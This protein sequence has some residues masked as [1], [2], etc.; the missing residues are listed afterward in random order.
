MVDIFIEFHVAYYNHGA[1]VKNRLR[2]AEYYLWGMFFFDFIPVT[3]MILTSFSY[4][5]ANLYVFHLLF[6]LKMYPVY[7]MD[8]RFVD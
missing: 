1:L 7:E 6:L 4:Y 8:Q 5:L 2:V 3:V